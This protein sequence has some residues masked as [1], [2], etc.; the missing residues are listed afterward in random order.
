MRLARPARRAAIDRPPTARVPPEAHT[1]GPLL[2]RDIPVYVEFA[3]GHS[4]PEIDLDQ[5]FGLADVALFGRVGHRKAADAGDTVPGALNDPVVLQFERDGHAATLIVRAF[6]GLIA[7][8]THDAFV[9]A[10]VA[11]VSTR[12]EWRR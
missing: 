4:L 7:R 2:H 5:E 1:P 11:K 6:A 12:I 10:A 8:R 3:T 9:A